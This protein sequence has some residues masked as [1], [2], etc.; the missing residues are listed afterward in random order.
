MRTPD[1]LHFHNFRPQRRVVDLF[2]ESEAKSM[3]AGIVV[4]VAVAVEVVAECVHRN[5]TDA[6]QDIRSGPVIRV[7]VVA[8]IR[9]V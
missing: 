3:A 4:S 2:C 5:R 8:V 1:G 6:F 9:A 7:S